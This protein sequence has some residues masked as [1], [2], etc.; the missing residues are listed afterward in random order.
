MHWEYLKLLAENRFYGGFLFPVFKK[1]IF[2]DG[3]ANDVGMMRRSLVSPTSTAHLCSSAAAIA[4]VITKWSAA[5][6]AY[7]AKKPSLS[8]SALKITISIPLLQS[9][10]RICS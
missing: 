5:T 8:S 4:L 9:L 1:K 2:A 6:V 10:E 3:C 7:L